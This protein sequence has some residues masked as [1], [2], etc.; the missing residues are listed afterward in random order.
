VTSAR[1]IAWKNADW[2][3]FG[4]LDGS[5]PVERLYESNLALAFVAPAGH[6]NKKYDVHVLVIPKQH[7]ETLLDVRDPVL[8]AAL[9]DAIAEAARA[10]RL[11]EHGFF[12]R[13]NVLP[14]YQGTGHA[15][16][17]LLSGKRPKKG[18]KKA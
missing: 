14:P 13:A 9:V 5:V 15:H 3:C 16:L 12:V 11:E 8:A 17:H 7:V 1:T 4:I 6:R 2:F 10:L 18:K